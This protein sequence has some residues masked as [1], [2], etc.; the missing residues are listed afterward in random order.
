MVSG[1][2]IESIVPIYPEIVSENAVEIMKEKYEE[3]VKLK[4]ELN[5][6]R[7]KA[8]ALEQVIKVKEADFTTMSEVFEINYTTREKVVPIRENVNLRI[9]NP[10]DYRNK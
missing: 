8:L 10:S 3:L 6:Y 4:D 7:M 9:V 5:D 1:E 2:Q